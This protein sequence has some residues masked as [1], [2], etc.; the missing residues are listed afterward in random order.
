MEILEN[1]SEKSKFG[2]RYTISENRCGSMNGKDCMRA[3]DV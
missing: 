3:S 2:L 1:R